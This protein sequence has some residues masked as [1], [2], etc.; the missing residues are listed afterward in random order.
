MTCLALQA[1]GQDTLAWSEVKNYEYLWKHGNLYHSSDSSHLPGE[2]PSASWK[3]IKDSSY[4]SLTQTN[5]LKTLVHN[6]QKHPIYFDFDIWYADSIT[7]WAIAPDTMFMAH[8]GPYTSMDTWPFYDD[9]NIVPIL[10]APGQTLTLYF[11]LWSDRGRMHSIQ[12]VY[13]QTREQ[14]LLETLQSYRNFIGQIEFN[15]F[16]LGAVCFAMVFFI[17]IYIKVRETLFLLYSLYLCGAALYALIV[18]SL[19]YSFIARLAYLDYPLTYKLGEPIQYLFFAAYVGFGKSL[20]DIDDRYPRLNKALQSFILLLVSGGLTLLA[21]NLYQLDFV[22][23]KKAFQI[24]RLIILPLSIGGLIWIGISVKN[25]LK[26]FLITG[27]SF[28]VLGGLAAIMVDPKT[29]HFFFGDIGLNPIVLFKSGILLESICFA[30]ALGYKIRLTQVAKEQASKDYIDQLVLNRHMAATENERLE[31]MVAE[32][33]A[34]VIDKTRQVEVQK[35]KRLRADFERRLSEMEMKAL[36]SQMNP[37]F[38]FNSLNSIRYQ[39]LSENYEMASNYLTRFAKLLR[40]ILQNSREHIINLDEEIEMNRLYL[41]L[42]SLRFSQGF[43]FH[44]NIPEDIDLSDIIVP[45]MLLQPYIENAIKHGLGPSQRNPKRV[46]ISVAHWENGYLITIED[47]GIGRKMAANHN[48]F[49]EKQSL[50]M[51]ISDERIALFNDHFQTNIEVSVTDLYEDT[52]ASG[53][54]IS[55]IYKPNP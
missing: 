32:R 4:S 37:H 19:P 51:I 16:F 6:D 41:Q 48:R 49:H 29:R 42:E 30:L 44:F 55:F 35:Q 54:R 39:I 5:W 36:R 8:A 43:E 9:P 18:K 24:S 11:R 50:G 40:Y 20:L 45:P 7:I 33:T 10:C 47:N 21:Y 46:E 31:R 22:L 28:F 34:E 1:L 38:I 15:G 52:E 2:V 25:S 53:T 3:L 13:I 12:D 26:W 17:F 14:S 27:S 23:Q